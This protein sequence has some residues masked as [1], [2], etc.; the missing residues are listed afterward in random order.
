M[1]DKF[2]GPFS[3][4]KNKT[5]CLLG[6]SVPLEKKHRRCALLWD[7]TPV[8]ANLWPL[9]SGLFPRKDRVLHR[10]SDAEL[11]R[12]FRGDLNGFAG[13]RVAAFA[14]LAL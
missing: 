12:R 8:I 5:S 11:E 3:K 14:G 6:A 9:S 10:F 2:L 1:K 7:T 4:E 13:R